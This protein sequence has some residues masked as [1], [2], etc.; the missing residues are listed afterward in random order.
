MI[1]WV[2][3]LDDTLYQLKF[4]K[5]IFDYR[6]IKYDSYLRFLIK[7]LPGKRHIFSN[8][9]FIHTDK[10]LKCQKNCDL[11]QNSKIYTRDRM[12]C[13][14]PSIKSYRYVMN[15]I[16]PKRKDKIIF[17]DDRLEN[18]YTAK[19]QGWVTVSISPHSKD[20]YK[21]VDL[22]F[23]NICTALEFFLSIKNKNRR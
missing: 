7:K 3:D 15:K 6:D 18:L 21:F 12:G 20:K 5:P 16:K 14:K 22:S 10:V 19:R 23:P 17:F 8:S 11:F 9:M 1:H 13:I 4:V 2:F